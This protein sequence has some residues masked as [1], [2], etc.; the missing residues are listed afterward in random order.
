MPERVRLPSVV[1][2]LVDQ[3]VSATRAINMRRNR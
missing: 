2:L 1:S 3:I